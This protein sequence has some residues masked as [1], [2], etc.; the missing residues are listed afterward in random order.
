MAKPARV[1]FV[2]MGNSC[3]SQMAEALA[4]HFAPEVLAPLSAGVSP[5]GS[6]AKSTR[7]VL[8]ERGIRVDGQY[9]KG[10]DD[11]TV[12]A[13]ELIVNMSGI[14]RQSLFP[15]GEVEDWEVEDPYGDG[16]ETYR[17]VCDDIEARL[18]ELIERL[19][20]KE[21]AARQ[22]GVASREETCGERKPASRKKTT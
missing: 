7:L 10:L 13:P 22:E 18:Q 16:M 17:R 2:C 12:L 6:I 21:A 14:P 15:H 11:P 4:R 1:L 9:S 19:R 8:L 3:R 5:L 20:R